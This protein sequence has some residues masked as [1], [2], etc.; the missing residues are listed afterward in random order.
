[1]DKPLPSVDLAELSRNS[2]F[3]LASDIIFMSGHP[4]FS[5]RRI[6]R[7][8]RKMV[9]HQIFFVQYRLIYGQ[10]KRS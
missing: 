2:K 10:M 1:M 4:P 5:N 6:F 3:I 9:A 8:V 7:M